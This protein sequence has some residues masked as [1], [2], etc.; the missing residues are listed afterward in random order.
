MAEGKKTKNF[1]TEREERK[2]L[3]AEESL[4]RMQKYA[5]RREPFVATVRKIKDRC[6][7]A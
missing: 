5:K 6:V 2:K 4:K 7:S 3:S 1:A